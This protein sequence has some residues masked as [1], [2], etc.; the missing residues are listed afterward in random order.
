MMSEYGG[1]EFAVVCYRKM[2][3]IE[4]EAYCSTATGQARGSV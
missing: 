2:L 1:V 4:L 3:Q